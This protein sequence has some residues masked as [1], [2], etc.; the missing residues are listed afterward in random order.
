MDA[1]RLVPDDITIGIVRERLAA[2]DCTPGFLLD[3]F[4]RT[5]P[6]A[7]ALG[8]ILTGLGRRLDAAVDIEVPGRELIDRMAGRRIC[9]QCGAAYNLQ[10]NIPQQADRCDQCGGELYQ[11]SDDREETVINRLKVYTEQTEPLLTYY[12]QRGLLITVN[13]NQDMERVG[14]DICDCLIKLD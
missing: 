10:Y 9:R 3:G 8:E 2:E 13:G 6:Q 7:D 12:Q 1:G 14:R 11:R 4:P 5:I